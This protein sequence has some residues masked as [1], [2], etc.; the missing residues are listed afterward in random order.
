MTPLRS[1]ELDISSLTHPLY[2]HTSMSQSP[3]GLQWPSA[4]LQQSPL[5]LQQSQVSLQRCHLSQGQAQISQRQFSVSQRQAQVGQGQLPVSQGQ[6]LHGRGQSLP[7]QGQVPISLGQLPVGGWKDL[8]PDSR[9]TMDGTP[10]PCFRA[11]AVASFSPAPAALDGQ[12]QPAPLSA[13][14]AKLH[15]VPLQQ[16]LIAQ[17]RAEGHEGIVQ[18]SSFVNTPVEQGR[19]STVAQEEG[20]TLAV[21]AAS[22]SSADAAD[23]RSA[24]TTLGACSSWTAH[25][26]RNAQ[27]I[28]ASSALGTTDSGHSKF[29]P[30]SSHAVT[31]EFV[32]L[33]SSYC[34]LNSSNQQMLSVEDLKGCTHGSTDRLSSA[35]SSIADKAASFSVFTDYLS[36]ALPLKYRRQSSVGSD[37]SLLS[38]LNSADLSYITNRAALTQLGTAAVAQQSRALDGAIS[39]SSCSSPLPAGLAD[40]EENPQHLSDRATVEHRALGISRALAGHRHVLRANVA[41]KHT[42]AAQYTDAKLHSHLLQLV[43]DEDTV[44]SGSASEDRLLWEHLAGAAAVNVDPAASKVHDADMLGSRAQLPSGADHEGLPNAESTAQQA[45]VLVLPD[46]QAVRPCMRMMTGKFDVSS[47]I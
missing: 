36:S 37:K 4:H 2:H 28:A 43:G 12:Y 44:L 38:A 10:E 9:A 32:D 31:D 35:A 20:C 39:S 8:R 34:V 16:A 29:S 14:A 1:S 25:C 18:Q 27:H 26:S 22:S 6:S 3:A 30:A 7:S 15:I 41:P 11:K 21:P 46:M 23:I 19:Y 33:D 42:R 40:G 45:D 17:G 5:D 24:T 13:D 47:S